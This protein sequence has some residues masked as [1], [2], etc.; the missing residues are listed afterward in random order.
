MP[1]TRISG[2]GAVGVLS[3]PPPFA[4]PDNALS[5]GLNIRAY[6]G[7]LMNFPGY[8]TYATPPIE[9]YGIYGFESNL[10][11]TL[12]VEAGLTAVYVYD[13]STHSDITRVSGPYTMNEAFNRWT[14]GVQGSLG[15]LNNAAD[16]P[17]QWDSIDTVTKLKDMS[18]DP[19][20]GQSWGDLNYR[21]F[22]MRS[23]R[24]TIIAM[25]LTRGSAVLPS[26]LQWC[27]FFRP[28]ETALDWVPRAS[29]SAREVNLGETKGHIIDGLALREDFIIYKEDA[30]YR[31]SF[32]GDSNNPFRFTRLPEFVRII[33]RNCV[34]EAG[35]LHVIAAPEDVYTFDGNTFR[36]LLDHRMREHYNTRLWKERGFQAFVVSNENDKE[37]WI[38]YPTPDEGGTVKYA[39]EAIV[40]N[41]HDDTLSITDLPNVKA[42]SRG[43][44]GPPPGDNFDDPPDIAFDDDTQAFD[45]QPFTSAGQLVGTFGQNLSVFAAD[46]QTDNGVAKLCQGE[47]IG[48]VLQDAGM[49]TVGRAH[50]YSELRPYITSTGPVEFSLGG[51]QHPNGPVYW[52]PFKTFDPER[53][54]HL[55]FRANGRYACWRIRSKSNVRWE[56][57]DV[58]IA[59]KVVRKK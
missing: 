27:Q 25:N 22:A 17:Q 59:H 15:F 26:T 39:T 31:M 41:R 58:E 57:S 16:A 48:L 45:G 56:L 23:F 20:A 52:E 12:W 55:D 42:M 6:H 40:W 13:G 21:C 28:G 14:G 35:E 51:Q 1:T 37:V 53:D 9:P 46:N 33:N 8:T 3:D 5:F 30:V 32:T 50:R 44:L 24:G 19:V 10:A 36:S 34:A 4:T 49:S 47:R 2:I 7:R 43:N 18:Y 29:N 11:P 38:C 54:Y